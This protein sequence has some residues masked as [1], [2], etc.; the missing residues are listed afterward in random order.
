MP[1]GVVSDSEF[2]K[3]SESLL[4][5]ESN[6]NSSNINKPKF[7]IID[8][9]VK[10]NSHGR[11]DNDVQVPDTVRKLIGITAV[12]E[13]RQEALALAKQFG[14]SPSQT[15]AYSQG[16]TSSSSDTISPP[17][18][19]A[20]NKTKLRIRSKAKK[21]LYI[22]LDALTEDR[23]TASKARDIAAIAKDMS[24]IMT[25]MEPKNEDENNKSNGPT[26]IFFKPE[27]KNESDFGVVHS[28]E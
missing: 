21:S 18:Q 19:S 17:I 5:N 27:V 6:I 16:K 2:I 3:E 28:R 23:I 4:I 8:E 24:T 12:G 14:I 11:R 25:S 9:S 20:I 7:E 15:S 10:N 22:A 13:G 1:M 26:F